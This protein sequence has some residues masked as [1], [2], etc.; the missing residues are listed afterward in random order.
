MT[1]KD[2]IVVGGGPAG[3]AVATLLV[4][5]GYRVTLLERETFPRFQIGESLLP[6]NNDLLREL[7]VWDE[8]A[9]QGFV[10]KQGAEFLTGTGEPRATFSFRRTLEERYWK[11][12]R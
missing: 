10:E 12:F 9:A 8:I 4:R 7:G 2:L 3:S 6:Y 5:R 1:D 11:T